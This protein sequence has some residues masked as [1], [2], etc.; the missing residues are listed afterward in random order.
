MVSGHGDK[1]PLRPHPE[2]SEKTRGNWIQDTQGYVPGD[3]FALH[4]ACLPSFLSSANSAPYLPTESFHHEPQLGLASG[5]V[6]K[7]LS[8]FGGP[9]SRT[10][11]PLWYFLSSTVTEWLLLSNLPL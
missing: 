5:Q 11:R 4:A 8:M 1:Y 6:I 10:Y 3:L 7:H 9:I 2:E